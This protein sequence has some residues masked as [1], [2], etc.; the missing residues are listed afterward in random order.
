MTLLHMLFPIDN[1]DDLISFLEKSSKDLLKPLR[2]KCPNT[3]FFL[4]HIFRAEYGKIGTRKNSLFEHIS[5]SERFDNNLMKSNPD[6]SNIN[7]VIKA[8]LNY[9]SFFYEKILQ[10]QKTTKSTKKHKK[11]PKAQ[12]ST[13]TQPNKSTKRK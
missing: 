5:H 3:E 11:A 2:E 10:A 1:I 4:V 7:E 12:K 9:L 8:V 6:S 13:K